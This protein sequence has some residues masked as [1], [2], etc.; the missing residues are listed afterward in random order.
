MSQGVLILTLMVR[1]LL[2]LLALLTGLSAP[3]SVAQA[4]GVRAS[5]VTI[6]IGV[7]EA[8]LAPP[9][10][11]TTIPNVSPSAKKPPCAAV[12]L[13]RDIRCAPP[14]QLQSDRARE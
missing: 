11:T 14:V 8:R 3:F 2:T 10:A 4:R 12:M 9:H 5:E 1:L 13:R 7:R 6:D